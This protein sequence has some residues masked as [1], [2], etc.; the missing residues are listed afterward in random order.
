M[1]KVKYTAAFPFPVR[2]VKDSC[3]DPAKN[4]LPPFIRVNHSGPHRVSP[5]QQ[6]GIGQNM[7]QAVDTVQ[8]LLTFA[9]DNGVIRHP[10]SET[11]V[12]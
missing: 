4:Y 11:L 7:D 2:S 5:H 6:I 1:E 10:F 3:V 9:F 12:L 8:L